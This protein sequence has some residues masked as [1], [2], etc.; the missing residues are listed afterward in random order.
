MFCFLAF[1]LPGFSFLSGKNELINNLNLTSNIFNYVNLY[2]KLKIALIKCGYY[3]D[4][5]EK[6]NNFEEKICNL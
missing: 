6:Q 4:D 2:V 5:N 1:V 3:L